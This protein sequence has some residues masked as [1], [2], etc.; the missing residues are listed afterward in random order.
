M[1]LT[2]EQADAIADVL[3]QL[4]LLKLAVVRLTQLIGQ[5]EP[6]TRAD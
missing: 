3:A 5:A 6:P 1:I 4:E 2:R